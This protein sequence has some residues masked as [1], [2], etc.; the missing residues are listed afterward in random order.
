MTPAERE[1]YDRKKNE[2]RQRRNREEEEKKQRREARKAR[3]DI[4]KRVEKHDS[5]QSKGVEFMEYLYQGE[6]VRLSDIPFTEPVQGCKYNIGDS[7]GNVI[8]P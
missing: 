1:E 3:S 2:E 7:L 5:L 8:I 4:E 6:G